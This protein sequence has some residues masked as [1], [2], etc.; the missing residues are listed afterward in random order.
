MWQSKP[1]YAYCCS[2]Q[3]HSHDADRL[4]LRK[5]IS[6]RGA[7]L[8]EVRSNHYIYGQDGRVQQFAFIPEGVIDG[9]EVPSTSQVEGM[10]SQVCHLSLR[11]LS[12]SKTH[13]KALE[14]CC[15]AM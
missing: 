15:R 13:S 3:R 1:M 4:Y 9:E 2:C 11:I 7:C 12:A 14:F 6:S 5:A 10:L 8:Q